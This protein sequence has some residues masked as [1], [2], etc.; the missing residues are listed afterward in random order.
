MILLCSPREARESC[1]TQRPVTL[2]GKPNLGYLAAMVFERI[3]IDT[4][5]L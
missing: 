1:R 3:T 5:D 4:A 2:D